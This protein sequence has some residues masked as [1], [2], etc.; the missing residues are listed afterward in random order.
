M[1]LF[2]KVEL[3]LTLGMEQ[4]KKKKTTGLN[5]PYEETSP[6]LFL[7]NCLLE[8]AAQNKVRLWGTLYMR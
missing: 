7:K 8:G 6:R 4:N 1:N 2:S 5:L 3:S